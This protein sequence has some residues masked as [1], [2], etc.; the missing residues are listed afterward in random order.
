VP[1]LEPAGLLYLAY[2]DSKGYD[3]VSIRVGKDSLL[4]ERSGATLEA[5]IVM[6]CA[7]R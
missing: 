1:P 2:M 5:C 6:V 7:W 3:T 4:A